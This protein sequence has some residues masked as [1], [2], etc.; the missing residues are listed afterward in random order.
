M[1]R[2]LFLLAL[3][4]LHSAASAETAWRGTSKDSRVSGSG[5]VLD[6]AGSRLD[7]AA[8]QT[9][10]QGFAA[11][12]TSLDAEAY[13]GREVV[14]SGVLQV[15]EGKGRGALWIRADRLDERLEFQSTGDDPLGLHDDAQARELRLYVPMEATS[16]RFGVSMNAPGRTKAESLKLRSE[17]ASSS[18]VSAYDVLAAALSVIGSK[19]LNRARVDWPA[20]RSQLLTSGLKDLPAPEAYPRIRRALAK[21]KD[22]HSFLQIPATAAQY[23]TRATPTEAM[24]ASASGNVGY[25]R[26]PGLMGS[27]PE[28]SGAFAARVCRSLADMADKTAYGVIVDLRE[29]RGGNMW[30][31]VDGLHPLLGSRDVGAFRD[32]D[33]NTKPW[34]S[35][36]PGACTTDMTSK[37]VA[38]LIGSRTASSGE[39]VA[40]AFQGRPATRFFG[41]PTAGLST[42]NAGFVLPDGS[43]LRL[44]TGVDVDRTGRAF[45]DGHTPDVLV[46]D[47]QDAIKVAGAW[48]RS[49]AQ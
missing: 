4:F 47:G 29:D 25:L 21:L 24:A 33:G 6:R 23:R 44:T 10:K 20:E 11:A 9:G 41:R 17:A 40:T 43:V 45:P 31:M 18:G 8:A 14:L 39:A 16:L 7:L 1:A 12:M 13:R 5:D 26:L 34:K 22:H 28:A 19:A 27:D 42:A 38:V 35:R 30:P 37:P 32:A 46:D 36:T 49:I 48:L 15:E 2:A 3:I